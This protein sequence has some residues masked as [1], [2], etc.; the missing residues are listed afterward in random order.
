MKIKNGEKLTLVLRPGGRGEE[1]TVKGTVRSFETEVETI[2]ALEE[3]L[4]RLKASVETR[5][6]LV[7]DD[8]QYPAIG[9]DPETAELRR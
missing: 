4:A 5:W 6:E 9:F 2:A 1:R 3:Q 7:T 8:P